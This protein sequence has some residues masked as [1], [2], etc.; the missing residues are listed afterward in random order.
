MSGH[1]KWANIK[2]TKGKND[3]QRGK[4]FTK[5]GKEIAVAVKIG[6]AD[7]SNNPRLRDAIAKAKQNNL[8]GDNI[9][10]SI[11]KA[12]GELGSINYENITYEGYGVGGSAVMVECLTDNK[13]R[14][15]G[16]IRHCFDKCGGALSTTGSVS[17]SFVRHG[18]LIID[19]IMNQKEQKNHK[20]VITKVAVDEDGLMAAALDAGAGDMQDLGDV[21]EVLTD[22]NDY[23]AVKEKLEQKGFEF[24]YSGL[25]Y[26]PEN[27][28]NLSDEQTATFVKMID[29]LNDLDDVQEVY[30]NVNL[31][32]EE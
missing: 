30:H 4:V 31:P 7:P 22:P 18:V 11:K 20:E 13:N 27:Y 19:K 25:D 32:E 6:G 14:T 5:I 8:P 24:T 3:A 1:S 28:I 26:V 10:R 21:F 15:A 23:I 9:T 2:R 17:Y 29:M 16:D 12:S